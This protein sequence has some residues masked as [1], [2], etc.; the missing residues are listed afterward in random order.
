M[1]DHLLLPIAVQIF[2][3][4]CVFGQKVKT[5]QQQNNQT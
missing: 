4:I 3:K 1:D 5:Q 2:D